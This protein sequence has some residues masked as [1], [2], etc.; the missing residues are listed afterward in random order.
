LVRDP[1]ETPGPKSDFNLN[2]AAA[3]IPA[4]ILERL[5]L[6]RL[7]IHRRILPENNPL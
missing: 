3:M 4:A 7:L 1:L 2:P 6:P 5:G